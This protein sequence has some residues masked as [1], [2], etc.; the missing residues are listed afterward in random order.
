MMPL[1]QGSFSNKADCHVKGRDSSLCLH[2]RKVRCIWGCVHV[3]HVRLLQIGGVGNRY[4][5]AFCGTSDGRRSLTYD[6]MSSQSQPY[7]KGIQC[8]I[9][10]IAS[11][12]SNG[13]ARQCPC[14]QTT[15]STPQVVFPID[16]SSESPS[17]ERHCSFCGARPGFTER[18]RRMFFV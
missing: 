8:P 6:R 7:D 12:V 15:P 11:K 18:R 17:T 5:C 10:E 14:R 1:S 13:P 2:R 3:T 9:F 16:D 4:V